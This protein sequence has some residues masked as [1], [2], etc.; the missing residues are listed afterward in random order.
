MAKGFETPQDGQR[1]RGGSY[2]GRLRIAPKGRWYSAKDVSGIE[3]QTRDKGTR[4]AD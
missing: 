3:R 4:P 2:R 1:E